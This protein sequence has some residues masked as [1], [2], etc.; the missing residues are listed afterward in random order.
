MSKLVCRFC[1]SEVAK[2]MVSV[3]YLNS[4]TSR[5]IWSG[6]YSCSFCGR[7]MRRPLFKF[8]NGSGNTEVNHTPATD[9][10]NGFIKGENFVD[11]HSQ[12]RD[13]KRVNRLRANTGGFTFKELWTSQ[14]SR[15]PQKPFSKTPRYSGK[16]D[17]VREQV[18]LYDYFLRMGL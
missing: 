14:M 9:G 11:F 8:H 3:F 18:R 5:M 4:N 10:G 16:A 2:V 6:G 15:P 13:R 1:Q 7:T 12:A 17:M